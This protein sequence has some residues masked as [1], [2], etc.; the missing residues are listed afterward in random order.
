MEENVLKC[1]LHFLTF[2]T[3]QNCVGGLGEWGLFLLIQQ[4]PK[5]RPGFMKRP[6]VTNLSHQKTL[7]GRFLV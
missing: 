6:S 5:S 1:V 3:K 2:S 4:S 7:I